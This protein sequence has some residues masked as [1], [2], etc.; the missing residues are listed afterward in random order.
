[1]S[2]Q[3]KLA[4]RR[5]SPSKAPRQTGA[6]GEPPRPLRTSLIQRQITRPVRAEV[7]LGPKLRSERTAR[8]L[9]IQ[10]VAEAAGVTKSFLS[11]LETDQVSAS[12]ATLLRICDAMGVR[13]GTLFDPPS[14]NLVRDGE[15]RPI[16][17]GG[18]G[19]VEYL[20]SGDSNEHLMALM[21]VIQP[22]GGSGKEPYALTSAVDIVHI[23]QGRL[24]VT[25][26]GE[27]FQMRAG[28]TLTFQPSKPHAWRNPSA[29]DVTVAV[30]VI[31]P[32]P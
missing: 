28:D 29:S 5:A 32:P 3:A 11:K 4:L 7:S 16:N 15:A 13:P 25:I 12:V 9:S 31:V 27:T 8:G 10:Q 19:M 6:V 14:T 17:L 20:I 24:D 18:E 22:G 30:W 2:K 1:M 21:S 26:E 23:K